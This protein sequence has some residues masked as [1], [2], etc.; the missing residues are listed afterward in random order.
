MCTRCVTNEFY[1]IF[2]LK[3]GIA[4]VQETVDAGFNFTCGKYF[5]ADTDTAVV[6]AFKVGLVESPLGLFKKATS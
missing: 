6:A 4:T 5:S 3:S 1:L 2:Y